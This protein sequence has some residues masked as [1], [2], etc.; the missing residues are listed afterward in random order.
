MGRIAKVLEFIRGVGGL[1]DA[2]CDPGG[3]AIRQVRHFQGAGDDSP[4]LPGDYA[5]LVEVPQTGGF[6]AVG[7]V[8]P[9]TEQ[10]A[11]PGE[12]RLYARTADGAQIVE[13]WLKAD[14]S[15]RLSNAGG[16]LELEAE[17]DVVGNGARMTRDG[18]VVTSDGVSLRR[19]T[20]AQG[21]DSDNNTE[22]ETEPPTL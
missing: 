13:L 19:H 1:S 18:D 7:Y 16:Y 3:G 8:D 15:A 22:Q 10:T 14:G 2:K 12:R 4:P 20:H 17:G 21:N 11:A 5:A 6:V 9:L